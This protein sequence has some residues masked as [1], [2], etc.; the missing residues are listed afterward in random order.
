VYTVVVRPIITYAAMIWWPSLKF[1]ISQAKLSK[2]QRLACLGVTGA[3]RTAPTAAIEVF[4]GLPPLHLKIAAEARAGIY[5][6]GCNEQWRPKSLWYGHTSIAQDMI[7]QPILQMETDK[8]TLRYALHKPFT[9]RL[10]DRSEWIG[11]L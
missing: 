3:M 9:V 2:L 4:L 8:M 7:K 5:R 6:L 1:K 10:P 11:A